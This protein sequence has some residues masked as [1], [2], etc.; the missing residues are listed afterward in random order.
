M[1]SRLISGFQKP[2]CMNHLFSPFSPIEKR[3]CVTLVAAI[4]LHSWVVTGTHEMAP[5]KIRILQDL[6][7]EQ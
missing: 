7:Q 4:D 2:G 6:K 3:F 1:I 5:L